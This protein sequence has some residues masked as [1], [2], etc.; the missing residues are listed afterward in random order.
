MLNNHISDEEYLYRGVI[1]HNWDYDNNRPSSATFKDSKGASVD[2]DAG[3]SEKD[4]I[5]NLLKVRDF[6]AVCKVKT[7][8]VRIL[9]A[10]VLYKPV[11]SN[12]YHSEIH[13]SHDRPRLRGSKPNK[14]RDKSEIV[15]P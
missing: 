14:I 13:D 2:R 7:Y 12:I 15:Y 4:C 3:R 8:D 10:I 1:E 5:N 11:E 6:H 9:N